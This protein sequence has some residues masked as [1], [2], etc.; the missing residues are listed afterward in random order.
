MSI[1]GYISTSTSENLAVSFAN[2]D[3]SLGKHATV[4]HIHWTWGLQACWY[5]DKSA[6]P[7]EKEILL[8]DGCTFQ[9]LSVEE[10][11]IENKKVFYIKLKS[12]R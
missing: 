12:K 3:A 6:Y 5:F 1:F 9:V 4:F 2:S 11:T 7:E 8:Y 10:R